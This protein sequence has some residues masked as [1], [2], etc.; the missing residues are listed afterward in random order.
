MTTAPRLKRCNRCQ[1]SKQT[2]EFY[3]HQSTTDGLERY[4]QGMQEGQE[5]EVLQ[6]GPFPSRK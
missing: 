6:E 2:T 4:V 5:T 3:K 1:Q